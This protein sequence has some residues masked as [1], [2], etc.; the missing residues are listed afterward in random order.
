[1]LNFP[2]FYAIFLGSYCYKVYSSWSLL[3]SWCTICHLRYN[4]LHPYIC[5]SICAIFES[6]SNFFQLLRIKLN[7]FELCFI[8][9]P[10]ET[11]KCC[12]L[13]CWTGSQDGRVHV[14]GSDSGQKLTVLE[15]NHPGPI[16]CVAFNPKYMMLASACTN[17]VSMIFRWCIHV[18]V[19]IMH[20]WKD[21]R[22]EDYKLITD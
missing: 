9:L 13:H 6:E 20:S 3:H 22:F 5:I 18:C 15:G 12:L 11:G 1:M 17:M 8:T 2:L 10:S 16:Q 7:T 19:H 4:I 21:G 14:W